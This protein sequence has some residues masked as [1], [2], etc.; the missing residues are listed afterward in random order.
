MTD[1]LKGKNIVV[2]GANSGIG[3]VTALQLAGMGATIIMVCRD[4]QRGSDAQRRIRNAT[5]NPNVELLLAD[6]SSLERIRAVADDISRKYPSLHVLINNAGGIYGTR[7]LTVDGLEWTFAVNPLAPFLL[8]NLLVP[9]LKAGAP[10]RIITVSSSAHRRG[11][12]QFDDLMMSRHYDEWKAYS[13]SKLANVLFSAE[14][15]RRLPIQ[16]TSNSLHPGAVR[17]G[18]GKSGGSLLKFALGAFG[19][20]LLSPQEG[21]RT[22]V[23]LASSPEVTGETGKYF[24][25]CKAVDPSLEAR[26]RSI[27][28]RLWEVS[29]QLVKL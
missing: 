9:Q 23:F 27:A 16:V 25:R 26:D 6:L 1:D 8:T 13:Q 10:S 24:V 19:R 28:A 15:A 21:A 29:E 18:F 22:T 3:Y 14:L 17:T 11:H 12:I 20:L 2:T 5:S 7:T 4:E